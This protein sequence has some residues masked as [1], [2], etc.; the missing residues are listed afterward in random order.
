[1]RCGR[2]DRPV[3]P[4]T[5]NKEGEPSTCN[6]RP[7]RSLGLFQNPEWVR[8]E[9]Q[10]SKHGTWK[11][12]SV[13]CLGALLGFKTTCIVEDANITKISN[14]STQNACY[15]THVRKRIL[16]LTL[17]KKRTSQTCICFEKWS[18]SY[19]HCFSTICGMVV[20][21]LWSKRPVFGCAQSESG[22]L[23]V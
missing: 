4:Q 17:T 1:M 5:C 13:L 16:L 22:P 20:D 6:V 15:L 8:E 7:A 18:R 10:F 23:R 21:K 19:L 2:Q 9:A 11:W 14:G 12:A 3:P